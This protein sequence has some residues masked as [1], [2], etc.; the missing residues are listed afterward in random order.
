MNKPALQKS[1]SGKKFTYFVIFIILLFAL[2]TA[3][4]YWAAAKIEETANDT[5]RQM[6]NNGTVVD[7][8]DQSVDG[9]PFRLGV[10]CS[11]VLFVD[12]I[13]AIN[14]TAGSFRSAAQLYR[15]GHVIAELDSPVDLQVPNLAPLS[16]DWVSL[17]S[18]TNVTTS[19]LQRLSIEAANFDI[20]AND[21]G[22][23]DLLASIKG[24]QLHARPTPEDASGNSLDL[25][26][27]FNQWKIADGGTDTIEP[28]DLNLDISIAGLKAALEQRQDVISLLRQQGGKGTIRDLNLTTQTGGEISISGPVQIDTNGLLSGEITLNITDPQ[29]LALYAAKVFPPAAAVLIQAMPYIESFAEATDGNVKIKDLKLSINQGQVTLGFFPVGEIP[30]LF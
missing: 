8:K 28:I 1:K 26:A 11:S 2:F 21:F 9:Y 10:S 6:A 29:T 3:G 24:L 4:W 17:S 27:K 15:P 19:G 13:N 16:L 12:P 23:K 20:S 7:C 30:R 22:T 5:K 25:A 14:L 18:S